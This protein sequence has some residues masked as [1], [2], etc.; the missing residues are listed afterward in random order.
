[1]S[2]TLLI[3]LTLSLALSVSLSLSLSLALA[4]HAR[5]AVL[6]REHRRLYPA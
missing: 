1:M 5:Q 2:S 3:S 6:H 4:R